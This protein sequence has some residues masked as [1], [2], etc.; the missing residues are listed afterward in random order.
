MASRSPNSARWAG[1][2]TDRCVRSPKALAPWAQHGAATVELPTN[3]GVEIARL[4]WYQWHMDQDVAYVT[5]IADSNMQYTLIT[6]QYNSP[7]S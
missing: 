3:I 1:K 2:D 6:M 5:N 7:D 4:R